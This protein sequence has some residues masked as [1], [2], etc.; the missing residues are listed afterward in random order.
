MRNGISVLIVSYNDRE[1]MG[2][3]L[4]ALRRDLTVPGDE[5]IVVDNGSTDGVLEDLRAAAGEGTPASGGASGGPCVVLIE[6]GE[7][8]GF[9]V[10]CNIGFAAAA[11]G[12]DIFLLNNDA[13]LSE[14]ALEHLTAALYSAEDVGAV[15]P[16]SN[17][18]LEQI[19]PGA[20]GE[21]AAALTYGSVLSFERTLAGVHYEYRSRLTGFAVLIRRTVADRLLSEDG[22]LMDPRFS[23]GYFEDEDLGVRIAL[24]GYRQILCH[25]AF[26]YHKGGTGFASHPEAMERGRGRFME[27]WGFD[28]WAYIGILDDYEEAVTRYLDAGT[29]GHAGSDS[30]GA[31]L[32]I[33]EID[34]GMGVN[35]AHLAYLYPGSYMLGIERDPVIAQVASQLIDVVLADPEEAFAAAEVPGSPEASVLA[36]GTFDIVFAWDACERCTDPAGFRRRLEALLGPGGAII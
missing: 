36:A 6:N 4:A 23:P 3:C 34:C 17:N 2:R 16:V 24:A 15:G 14:G 22:F 1:I 32:R 21:L 27:K 7:N 19:E 30:A 13:V 25:D 9:P 26:V 35:L 11:P 5:V 18:A 20:P 8:A 31:S 33:L 10:G 12:N 28:A 29:A